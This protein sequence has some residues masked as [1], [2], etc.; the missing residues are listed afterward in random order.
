MKIYSNT[1][2]QGDLYNIARQVP[3]LYLD[4]AFPIKSPKVRSK[5]WTVR[6]VG[7]TNRWKNSG[8][9]GAESTYSASYD[10]H[11][12][13]FALL[14]A[15]DPDARIVFYENA[16]DFHKKTN[17]KYQPPTKPTVKDFDF[18]HRLHDRRPETD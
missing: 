12:Q 14:Y 7:T 10:Q 2:T 13:W 11:G 3:G 15:I 8:T 18:P 6:T 1:L 9:Y 17:N 4:G 16:A 5:G